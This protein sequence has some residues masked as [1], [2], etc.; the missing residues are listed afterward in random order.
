MHLQTVCKVAAA[1]AI[2]YG[3]RDHQ[4]LLAKPCRTALVKDLLKRFGLVGS[5][6]PT[7]YCHGSHGSGLADFAMVGEV[8]KVVV[9]HRPS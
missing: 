6:D 5:R 1:K 3:H 7:K 9:D 2:V 4:L 8:N